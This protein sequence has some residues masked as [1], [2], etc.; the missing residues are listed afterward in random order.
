MHY[1][2]LSAIFTQFHSSINQELFKKYVCNQCSHHEN[3]MM[4]CAPSHRMKLKYP[5][6]PFSVSYVWLVTQQYESRAVWKAS[7]NYGSRWKILVTQRKSSHT[8]T[9][10]MLFTVRKDE[11]NTKEDTEECIACTAVCQKVS[12]RLKRHRTVKNQSCS[13]SHYQVTLV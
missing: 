2:S 13:L 5:W 4:L 8:T 12:L 1:D 9:K 6:L 7:L 10:S 11:W 3:I